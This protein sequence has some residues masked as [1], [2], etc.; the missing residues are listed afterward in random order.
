MVGWPCGVIGPR[1]PE[2]NVLR[3]DRLLTKNR[4][5][6]GPAIKPEHKIRSLLPIQT[7]RGVKS[8]RLWCGKQDVAQMGLGTFTVEVAVGE[9][10]EVLLEGFMLGS[11]ALRTAVT[12]P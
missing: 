3:E 1:L 4:G 9:Q 11:G 6:S 10:N 12:L 2:R 7:W 8:P 5:M